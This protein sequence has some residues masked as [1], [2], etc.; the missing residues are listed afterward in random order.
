M[1]L[2]KE[3]VS[4][5]NLALYVKLFFEEVLAWRSYTD[6]SQTRLAY[7]IRETLINL[8][9][10]LKRKYGERFVTHSLGYVT[11]S[12]AGLSETEL[13]D[14]LSLDDDV[15]TDV[16][17]YHTP[18]VRR[19]PQLLWLRLKND[20][21]SYLVNRESDGTS[22]IYWYHRQFRE[23]AAKYFLEVDEFHTTLHSRVA[24]YFIGRWHGKKKPYTYN[25]YLMGKLGLASPHSAADRKVAPQPLIYTS[26]EQEG[27][28]DRQTRYNLRKL[29]NLPY[30]MINANRSQEFK[31]NYMYSY[32]WLY[33]KICACSVQA[34]LSDFDLLSKLDQFDTSLKNVL[35]MSKSTLNKNPTTLP[36]EITGSLLPTAPQ[37][38]DL[39]DLI[40]QCY[41]EGVRDN[42]VVARQL[43]QCPR[44]ASR[45]YPGASLLARQ[46]EGTRSPQHGHFPQP[47]E[48]CSMADLT[49]EHNI[50]IVWDLDDGE[51][52][53]EFKLGPEKEPRFN[54][55]Q[56]SF[57]GSQ[58]VCGCAHQ[59]DVNPIVIY[60]V[61]SDDI[62]LS[63]VLD[64]VYPKFGFVESFQ[65]G[66]TK[67]RIIINVCGREADCFDLQ[68]HMIY[69]HSML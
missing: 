60:D 37:G 58:V 29:N 14:L 52:K 23:A 61:E 4:R 49:R 3:A 30:H 67:N 51:V 15:L 17:Q 13:A 63:L 28:M 47:A 41:R 1:S 16:F 6:A 43:L 57:D 66:L 46:R 12:R 35:Q 45:P 11:A 34:V 21:S 2:A 64:K 19:I 56:R 32:H 8:F 55:I 65:I 44:R 18:P 40:D 26:D 50:L 33:I 42:A 9:S 31:S 38:S 25:A 54:V 20:V 36:L 24:D 59:T 27:Y 5:C 10:R 48:L 22:V 53:S 68:R 62:S 69:I 7:T 39:W